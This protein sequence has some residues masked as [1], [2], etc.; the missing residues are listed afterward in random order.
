MTAARRLLPF[1]GLLAIAALLG[2]ATLLFLDVQPQMSEAESIWFLAVLAAGTVIGLIAHVA[3]GLVASVSVVALTLLA[4]GGV[5]VFA[6]SDPGPLALVMLV[7]GALALTG[8][9]L[10]SNDGWDSLL[11][12]GLAKGRSPSSGDRPS[13]TC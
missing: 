4:A 2:G 10:T 13:W 12:A 7:I 11:A 9:L 5:I 1:V 3:E 6:V 8:Q